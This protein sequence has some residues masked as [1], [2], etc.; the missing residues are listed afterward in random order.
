MK[1]RIFTCLLALLA[2]MAMAGCSDNSAEKA[3]ED[4]LKQAESLFE[5]G[6]YTKALSSIDSL[7]KKY[8]KAIEVRKSALKLYQNIELKRAQELVESSDKAFQTVNEE[9]EKMKKTVEALK[10][11]GEATGEQFTNLTLL[12]MKRDSLKTIFDVECAK[13]KYIKKRMKEV[14][15]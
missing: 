14:E 11:K 7:R 13:I 8:P 9:Y 12:R 3:A 1:A 2:V 6:D 5:K 10:E 15:Q 4:M